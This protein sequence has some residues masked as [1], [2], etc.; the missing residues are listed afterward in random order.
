MVAVRTFLRTLQL[1]MFMETILRD[2]KLVCVLWYLCSMLLCVPCWYHQVIFTSLVRKFVAL[3]NRVKKNSQMFRKYRLNRN[4]T[5]QEGESGFYYYW[6]SFVGVVF[7]MEKRGD[8]Y[9]TVSWPCVVLWVFFPDGNLSV[10][11][12]E[13]SDIVNHFW[14]GDTF[15]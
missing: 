10:R 9:R 1:S 4:E 15:V 3:E 12:L 5:K 2:A 8:H 6:L 13:F 11:K 7:G 14:L